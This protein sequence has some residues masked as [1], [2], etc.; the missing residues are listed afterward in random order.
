MACQVFYRFCAMILINSTIQEH[1]MLDSFKYEHVECNGYAFC[2][3][4]CNHM[5]AIVTP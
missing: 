2:V 4:Q 3:L 1:R 5:T